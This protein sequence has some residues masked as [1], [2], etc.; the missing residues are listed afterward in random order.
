MPYGLNLD[1]ITFEDK[2]IGEGC[3]GAAVDTAGTNVSRALGSLIL[4][5]RAPIGRIEKQRISTM[6]KPK[7]RK[8]ALRQRASMTSGPAHTTSN[9]IRNLPNFLS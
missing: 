9:E 8:F 1:I 4:C 3:L 2:V 7:F 6:G 5:I